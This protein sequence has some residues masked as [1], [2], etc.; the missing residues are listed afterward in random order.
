MRA[1]SCLQ[2]ACVLQ[3]RELLLQNVPN[4]D[5]E[6]LLQRTSRQQKANWAQ[7]T[8]YF[9]PETQKKDILQTSVFWEILSK[10]FIT[11]F[12]S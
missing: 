12:G 5:T 7:N 3:C 6:V 10:Q 8:N 11:N 9:T 4:K 2:E 1:K